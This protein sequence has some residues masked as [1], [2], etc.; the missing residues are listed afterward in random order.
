MGFSFASVIVA[1][2]A[3]AGLSVLAWWRYGG[4][5]AGFVKQRW[6]MVLGFEALF[7]IA[8]LA[9][10][11]VRLANPDLWHPWRGGEKPMDFAY[12]NAVARSTIMPPYDPWFAGGFL[13]YYYYGQFIVATMLRLTGI[14]PHVA[15]NI[16][17]PM[18]FAMTAGAAFSVVY[19]LAALTLRSRG[20]P[21]GSMRSPIYAGLG[22]VVLTAVA[23][24]IDGLIQLGEK[25]QGCGDRSGTGAR[26]RLL[27]EFAN[28]GPRFARP[29]D[30]RIPVLH[31]P[32]RRPPR[33]PHRHT[34]RH[35]GPRFGNRRSCPVRRAQA[36][37]R[38]VGSVGVAGVDYRGVANHQCVGLPDS[39]VTGRHLC[40]WRR[41]DGAACRGLEPYRR[42]SG[43]VGIRR[44]RR[45]PN[46]PAVPPELRTVQQRAGTEH[47]RAPPSGATWPY[48]ASSCSYCSPGSLTT[49]GEAC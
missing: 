27:A 24:N 47:R 23:G 35:N 14:V 16:A 48:T 18:L 25:V 22:A 34:V 6:R 33:P 9:F 28:D 17:V 46:L 10:L 49:G 39:P 1:L 36:E 37:S 11:A 7:L 3:T 31:V 2:L 8:F 15:Y 32:V 4:E 45:L 19:N 21:L 5:I 29:R 43:E 41:I 42:G 30:N 40:A 20:V 44:R 38:D 13:N 12:L 26:I